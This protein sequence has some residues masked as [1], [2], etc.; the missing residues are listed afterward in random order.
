MG[1]IFHTRTKR[2]PSQNTTRGDSEKQ[3]GRGRNNQSRKT[4]TRTNTRSWAVGGGRRR[5]KNFDYRGN[6]VSNF[7]GGRS[8][9]DSTERPKS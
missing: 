8:N 9:E 3:S 5:K 4:E 6:I 2:T 1:E 7:E